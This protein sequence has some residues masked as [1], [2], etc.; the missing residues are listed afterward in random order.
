MEDPYVVQLRVKG[1]PWFPRIS[2]AALNQ[3]TQ[4]CHRPGHCLFVAELEQ[5]HRFYESVGLALT[6]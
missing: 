1:L 4:L 5:E 6:T 3:R 2:Q